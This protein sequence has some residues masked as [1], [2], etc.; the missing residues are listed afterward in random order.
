MRESSL[1][2]R[3]ETHE[4][5]GQLL[6]AQYAF[7]ESLDPVRVVHMRELVSQFVMQSR[8]RRGQGPHDLPYAR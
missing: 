1:M 5:W 2:S 7:L 6:C 3:D 4:A 8:S